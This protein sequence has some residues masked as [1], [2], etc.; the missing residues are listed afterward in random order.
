MYGTGFRAQSS[1]FLAGNEHSIYDDNMKIIHM[2]MMI[3]SRVHMM[4][5]LGKKDVH[6][7]SLVETLAGDDNDN[8]DDKGKVQKKT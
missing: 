7:R 2:M 1:K 3:M 6:L 8:D 5:I 4:I